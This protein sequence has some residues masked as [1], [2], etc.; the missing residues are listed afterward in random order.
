[1]PSRFGTALVT[2]WPFFSLPTSRVSGADWA[3]AGADAA[4]LRQPPSE[5]RRD[6]WQPEACDSAP[7]FRFLLLLLPPLSAEQPEMRQHTLA[8]ASGLMRCTASV[9]R[10]WRSVSR[11]GGFCRIPGFVQIL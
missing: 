2:C 9:A 5:G 10:E 4:P 8:D 3:P 1:M 7:L 11:L 6:S